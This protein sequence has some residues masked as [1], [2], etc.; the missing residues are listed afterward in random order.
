MLGLFASKCFAGGACFGRTNINLQE[1]NKA[2]PFHKPQ[3]PTMITGKICKDD[4]GAGA[5][6]EAAG[7]EG[8]SCQIKTVPV[9]QAYYASK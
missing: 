7:P 5:A 1:A 8:G 6:K 2:K 4:K 3:F 9:V